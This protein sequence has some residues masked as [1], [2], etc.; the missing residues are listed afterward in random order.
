MILGTHQRPRHEQLCRQAQLRSTISGQAH[1]RSLATAHAEGSCPV[2][3][4]EENVIQNNTTEIKQGMTQ[5]KCNWW[6]S[7]AHKDQGMEDGSSTALNLVAGLLACT[8][9]DARSGSRC[10][11]FFSGC[12]SSGPDKMHFVRS[13]S[14]SKTSRNADSL[15]CSLVHAKILTQT[16][17][18][19]SRAPTTVQKSLFFLWSNAWYMYIFCNLRVLI[20]PQQEEQKTMRLKDTE[21]AAVKL[22]RCLGGGVKVEWAGTKLY[23]GRLEET[24]LPSTRAL[25]T[26]PDGPGFINWQTAAPPTEEERAAAAPKSISPWQA[27]AFATTRPAPPASRPPK[28]PTST[29]RTEEEGTTEADTGTCMGTALRTHAKGQQ[30]KTFSNCHRNQGHDPQNEREKAQKKEPPPPPRKG[31]FHPSYHDGVCRVNHTQEHPSQHH[32]NGSHH[33]NPSEGAVI[34]CIR[35]AQWRVLIPDKICPWVPVNNVSPPI[36]VCFISTVLALTLHTCNTHA[37]HLWHWF[38]RSMWHSRKMTC[39]RTQ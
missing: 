1:R 39:S 27:A 19:I 13:C 36:P 5:C 26:T 14:L 8:C 2:V 4:S 12:I 22:P 35:N 37:L 3:Q 11:L 30:P 18:S 28:T 31:W 32:L 23:R 7:P 29:P 16:P 24:V 10:N 9:E 25:G 17:A 34:V 38:H 6:L 20:K 21:F 33:P 15:D